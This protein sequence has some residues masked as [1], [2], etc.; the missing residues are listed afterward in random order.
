M[1]KQLCIACAV[2]LKQL[3]SVVV[4]APL[5][6]NLSKEDATLTLL[7]NIYIANNGGFPLLYMY[8]FQWDN[9]WVFEKNQH[10][11]RKAL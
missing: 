11:K 9:E 3:T 2:G 8:L 5:P 1:H 7:L 10:R 4:I 6:C